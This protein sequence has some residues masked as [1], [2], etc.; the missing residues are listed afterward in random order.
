MSND[1]EDLITKIFKGIVLSVVA[2]GAIASIL[3]VLIVIC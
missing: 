3:L 1:D 2:I